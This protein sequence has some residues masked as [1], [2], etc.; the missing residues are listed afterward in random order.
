MPRA[1]V[2]N[3][4]RR[5]PVGYKILLPFLVITLASGLSFAGTASYELT[6]GSTAQADGLLLRAGDAVSQRVTSF[7]AEQ[8]FGLQ[9]LVGVP[10]LASAVE[11][12][13]R[14][15]LQKLLLPPLANGAPAGLAVTVIGLD[16][17]EVLTLQPDAANPTACRCTYGRKLA[18]WVEPNGPTPPELQYG[19]AAD[20]EG[21]VSY[22]MAPILEAGRVVG[23]MM[24]SQPVT[25]LVD[26]LATAGARDVALYFSD[27]SLLAAS[28]DF[29][30]GVALDAGVRQQVLAG[31]AVHAAQAP[32]AA[33]QVEFVPWRVQGRSVG[34]VGISVPRLGSELPG[35]LAILAV[36][37][38]L[39][40]IACCLLGGIFVSRAISA[41]LARLVAATRAVASGELPEAVST[42]TEDEIGDLA[43]SFNQMVNSLSSNRAALERTMNGT[44]Q[45]L[46]AAIDARDPYTHG[47][48]VR[49]ADYA[50]ALGTSMGLQT[51]DLDLLRRACLVHDIGKIGVPDRIL[52]KAGPLTQEE[53]ALVQGHTVIGYRVLSHLAWEPEVLDVVRYHHERWDGRGYPDGLMATEIPVLA[54]VASLADALDAMT[55][56]RVYRSSLSF[57]EAVE[58]IRMGSGHQF[59]PEAVSAFL[60]IESVIRDLVDSTGAEAPRLAV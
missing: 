14:T 30:T 48:S 53:V 46:A 9:L 3:L 15:A 50:M 8:Q 20:L 59:D 5:L 19:I 52:L 49:V 35:R 32:W 39:A 24:I 57:E 37:T 41:P 26:A 12:R 18:A 38:F 44:I 33:M 7:Q 29:P 56:H 22:T 16:G 55:S 6:A 13:D 17:S 21:P 27:G 23:G 40:A 54:R 34:Y 4:A 45:T 47:H 60:A 58:Q 43:S 51:S 42:D 10:G 1:A 31:R 36:V 2:A 25:A 28:R 11:A